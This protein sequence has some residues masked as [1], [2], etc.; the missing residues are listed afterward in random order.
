MSERAELI[1]Q[2]R[3]ELRSLG[4]ALGRLNDTVGSAVELKGGDVE[5]LDRIARFGPASPSDLAEALGIHPATMTGILDRLEAGG[6]IIRERDRDD[7]RK[8]SLRVLRTRAPELVRLYSPMNNAIG[9]ICEQMTTDQLG[10]VHDFLIAVGVAADT[11]AETV[12]GRDRD[13]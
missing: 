10:A 4:A 2:V 6:W 5:L 3:L 13:R 7:R 12:R 8:V 9:D 1:Q 11:S